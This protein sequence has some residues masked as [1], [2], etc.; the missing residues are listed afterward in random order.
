M[1]HL[2]TEQVPHQNGVQSITL[3]ETWHDQ[4]P[5]VSHWCVF[6]CLVYT[7]VLEQHRRRLDDKAVKCIFFY[8]TFERK[9]C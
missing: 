4:K 1:C 7:L 3:Y 2:G 8:Y 5:F 9:G 6:G